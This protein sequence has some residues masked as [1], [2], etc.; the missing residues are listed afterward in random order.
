MTV[1]TT[2]MS[3]RGQVV[4]PQ[5][6]REELGLPEGSVFAVAGKKDTI[7]LKK[8]ATPPEESLIRDLEAIAREGR[9][10]MES[11]GIKESDIPSIVQRH[12][13]Q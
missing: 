3:S 5:S 1:E 7:V 11:K 6:I 2:R 8:V 13:R 4:I 9:M 12:R 10:R